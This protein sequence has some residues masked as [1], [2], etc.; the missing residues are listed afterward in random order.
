MV[1]VAGLLALAAG[2]ASGADVEALEQLW[3]GIRDTSEQVVVSAEGG[4]SPWPDGADRR[5][6]TV[7]SPV[8]LPWLGSHVLYLEEFLHDEPDDLR[9]QLLVKLEPLEPPVRG[10]RAQLFTFVSPRRWTHFNHRPNLLASLRASDIV[11][12]SGCDLVFMRGGDQFRG[13][14]V[15]RRCVDVRSGRTRYLDYELVI[16]VDLYWYRRRLLRK[17]DGE[18]QEEIV[19][20][21]WFEL[22]EARLFTCRVDW[23]STG[24]AQD[25]RPLVKLDLHDQGGRARFATPDGRK[26]ELTLH[27]Q[28]WPFVAERD[29]LILL[30]QDQGKDLPLASAWTAIDAEQIALNLEWLRVR[31]VPIVPETD[32]LRSDASAAPGSGRARSTL[33]AAAALSDEPSAPVRRYPSAT[34]D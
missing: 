21:N 30:V 1:L 34:P 23:S 22:N 28:D 19:G 10:V 12:S 24:H 13:G 27:T 26:L 31:C 6:R 25:L 9:R 2:A 3:S 11:T 29:A 33:A 32:E 20:F 5:V 16:G 17:S 8:D 7:V 15:G 4:I 18:I 14:T